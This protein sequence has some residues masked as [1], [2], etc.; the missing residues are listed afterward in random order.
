MAPKPDHSAFPHI[1]EL[2]AEGRSLRSICRDS[3]MPSVSTVMRWLAEFPD[4]REQYARAR[5][6]QADAFA[7]EILEIA[8]DATNDW[9]VR[10][11]ESG[12]APAAMVN[13][14]HISRSRLRVDARKWLMSKM[15][16]KKYGDKV[17]H[18]GDADNPVRFEDKSPDELRAFIVREA[19]ALGVGGPETAAPGIGRGSRTKPH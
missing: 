2:I 18:A 4:M 14:D 9:M 13:H 17:I 10:Q 15:A 16:P 8:D 6:L 11:S 3:G 19:A 12:G 1:C 7:E 5:E